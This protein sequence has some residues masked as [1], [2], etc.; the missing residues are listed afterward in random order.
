MRYSL[1]TK[2][3]MV[4][5][6]AFTLVCVLFVTFGMMQTNQALDRMKNSQLNSISY[7]LNLY[8]RAI[9]P[10]D[11]QQYFKNFNLEVVKDKNL[12][13]NVLSSGDMVFT[14]LTPVGEFISIRYHN[15][16]F[17]HIK[18]QSFNVTFE[19][20]GTKNLND[21]LWVGFF[22]TITLLISLYLSVMRSLSPLKKL[23]NNI[24]KF[25]AGNL[26]IVCSEVKGDDE[27]GELATEF[28]NAVSKIRELVRS[29]QLFLRAIMHELKTPIGKGRIV[30]EMIDDETQKARLINVFERLEILINEF[31]KIEQL[32]TKS[33][34]LNYQECHLSLILEQVKDLLMLDDWDKKIF[35]DLKDDVVINVDFQL[36]ALAIKNLIDNG[37]KYSDD[38]KVNIICT[39][40]KICIQNV[41]KPLAMS[42][43][44]YKQ[45][46]IRNRNE[47]V[48]GMGLGL[49]I[50]DK[51]SSMHK[52]CFDYFYSDS[53]H[54]FVIEFK[55]CAK[56][57]CEIPKKGKFLK[58]RKDK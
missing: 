5:A 43:E 48:S 58:K 10:Q 31:A 13:S 19:S 30:S 23:N 15:S 21:P 44:H 9:P 56:S 25:A 35:V 4:F 54:N 3:G 27:I 42:I 36:F 33:Y 12:V 49:Y 57:S 55:Q 51:I 22:L 52:F 18:N 46:F 1:S 32:L 28:D 38:R 40:E 11:I 41:G 53:T 26:E 34:S 37:L 2:I 7:L 20:I 6:I 16:L 14:N 29:R 50:V 8:D 45:A 24:K 47:K 39:K 17:L